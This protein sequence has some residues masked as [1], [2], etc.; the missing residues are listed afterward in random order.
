[1][2]SDR[3]FSFSIDRGGTFTDVFA[4]VRVESKPLQ[5]PWAA[6]GRWLLVAPA[7]GGSLRARAARPA[8]A[9]ARPP[10]ACK[11]QPSTVPQPIAC[12][13]ATRPP[14]HPGARRQ[15]RQHAQVS[16]R[17]ARSGRS[18]R[19]PHATA[20]AP[21]AADRGP[22]PRIF[23]TVRIYLNSL[24]T[25]GAE[26]AVGGPQQLPGC[27]PGGHPARAGGGHWGAAPEVGVMRGARC[28]N[29][30]SS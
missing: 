25:Q 1:M 24:P 13:P 9:A 22:H 5:P 16:W 18:W 30:V 3:D 12:T 27:P 26:A 15:G 21:C 29:L 4:Q 17:G 7:L 14:T 11:P 20:L 19:A 28:C 23:Y 10:P 8:P 6:G 2:G